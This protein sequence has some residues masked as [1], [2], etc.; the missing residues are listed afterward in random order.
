MV[1]KRIRLILNV[2]HT[3]VCVL[4]FYK[5]A[6]VLVYIDLSDGQFYLLNRL[7]IGHSS[8]LITVII[9]RRII[10]SGCVLP[11]ER[12]FP[13]IIQIRTTQM[14]MDLSTCDIYLVCTK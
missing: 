7:L 1:L 13:L 8:L 11:Q 12:I 14:E 9:C 10:C 2:H 6:W 4:I 5:I 3:C